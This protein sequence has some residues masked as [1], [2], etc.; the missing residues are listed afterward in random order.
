MDD[1]RFQVGEDLERY[2]RDEMLLA[3]ADDEALVKWL[4]TARVGDVFDGG[5]GC[6]CVKWGQ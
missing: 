4:K 2:T 1:A 3:N 6:R 5:Q